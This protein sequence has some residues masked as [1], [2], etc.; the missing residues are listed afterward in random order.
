M[1]T[2]ANRSKPP[3]SATMRGSAVATICESS[4]DRKT[5]AIKR[6]TTV[7][8]PADAVT[9][10]TEER[11]VTKILAIREAGSSGACERTGEE[12]RP[13]TGDGDGIGQVRT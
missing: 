11:E 5:A 4:R 12:H 2:Q 6:T 8:A 1:V 10:G 7:V 13:R 9:A 3:R